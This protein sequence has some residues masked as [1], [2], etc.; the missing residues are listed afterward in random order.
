MLRGMVADIGQMLHQIGQQA[1]TWLPIVFFGLIVYLLWRTVAM[2]PRIKPRHI[3]SN[4]KSSVTWADVAG[5]QEAKAEL[6]E[7]VD[8]LR[9][10]ERFERLGARVPK[11]IL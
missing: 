6:A 5:A 10:P 2:M 8:F 7:V 4:S 11:G 9:N 1:L 3:E